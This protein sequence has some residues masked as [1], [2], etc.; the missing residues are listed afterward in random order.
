MTGDEICFARV[1]GWQNDS[2]CAQANRNLFIVRS[3]VGGVEVLC[4]YLQVLSICLDPGERYLSIRKKKRPRK[5]LVGRRIGLFVLYKF[6]KSAFLA[7][8]SM[9]NNYY[10]WS[11]NFNATLV[12]GKHPE[13]RDRKGFDKIALNLIASMARDLSYSLDGKLKKTKKKKPSY[14]FIL[15]LRTAHQDA[16]YLVS[17]TTR[18]AYYII[19][20]CQFVRVYVILGK[21]VLCSNGFAYRH[22]NKRKISIHLS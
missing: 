3:T 6:K 19:I 18:T 11:R 16:L 13:Q 22:G 9:V 20:W 21:R 8:S 5:P 1:Y 2:V 4:Y 15:R 10:Y 12:K 7:T 14:H 17:T